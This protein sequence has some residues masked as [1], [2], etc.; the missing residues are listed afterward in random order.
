MFRSLINSIKIIRGITIA[1]IC[2]TLNKLPVKPSLTIL[3]KSI[4]ITYKITFRMKPEIKDSDNRKS[5]NCHTMI[6]VILL[7]A[8]SIK[9][10]WE[11]SNI[12]AKI[13]TCLGLR[14]NETITPMA[15][16]KFIAFPKTNAKEASPGNPT[17]L[18]IGSNTLEIISKTGVYFKTVIKKYTGTMAIAKSRV[19][20][21]P[22]PI[23]LLK[24]LS[25]TM[26]Y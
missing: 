20:D 13:V 21:R 19:T 11:S 10:E 23:P 9:S 14:D 25:V 8:L 22:L 24:V 15:G 2:K 12:S 17:N 5:T 18:M 6:P 7:T 4:M 3:T 1:P 16:Y 26:L